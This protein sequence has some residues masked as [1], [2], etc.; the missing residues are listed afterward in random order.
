MGV[1]R[2]FYIAN[3]AN[4]LQK[5][6]HYKNLEWVESKN[7][8]V[9]MK[10]RPLTANSRHHWFKTFIYHFFLRTEEGMTFQSLTVLAL[11]NVGKHFVVHLVCS[12]IWYSL[13]K[14]K[15]KKTQMHMLEL[16]TLTWESS[17]IKWGHHATSSALSL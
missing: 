12:A 13:K 11:G 6:F 8:N 17:Q 14:K 7:M 2:K 3:V 4:N 9:A 10:L 15:K 1:V 16:K 5:F